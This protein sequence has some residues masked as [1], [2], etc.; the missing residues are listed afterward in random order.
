MKG[1]PEPSRQTVA[2]LSLFAFAVLIVFYDVSFL[3]SLLE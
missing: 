3:L 2:A 1:Y